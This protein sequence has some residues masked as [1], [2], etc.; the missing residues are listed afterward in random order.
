MVVSENFVALFD[1]L[2]NRLKPLVPTLKIHLSDMQFTTVKL[3]SHCYESYQSY[4]L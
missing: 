4:D 1:F 3:V 2:P